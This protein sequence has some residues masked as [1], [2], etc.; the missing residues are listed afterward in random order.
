M[1]ARICLPATF[2]V[3]FSK[4]SFFFR[5]YWKVFSK[6]NGIILMKVEKISKAC[7]VIF[8]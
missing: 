6:N 7:C 5:K 8:V 1:E 4:I 3:D 2:V